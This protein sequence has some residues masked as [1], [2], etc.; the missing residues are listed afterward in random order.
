MPTNS[1]ATHLQTIGAGTRVEVTETGQGRPI[2]FLHPGIGL[3]GAEPFLKALGRLGRVV[4]PAHPGFHNSPAGDF[5]TIDDLSYLY[6]SLLESLEEPALVIGSSLGGWLALEAA[7]KSTANMAG[8]VLVNSVG[9]RFNTR[10]TPDFADLYALGSGELHKRMYHDPSVAKIDYPNT[11]MPEL[12]IIARNRE[13]E[14]RFAWAPYLHN[15]RLGSRLHRVNIP[16]L[17]VWGESDTFA[18]LGYGRKL[19]DALPS[20]LFETIEK[21]GHFPHIEQPNELVARIAR[22]GRHPAQ[23]VGAQRTMETAR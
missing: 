22:F 15:P 23:G 2:L 18:P 12:E 13:A 3:R 5:A 6:V 4:A 17:V 7:V 14:A 9:V 16:T 11:P 1:L 20:A 10:E 21:A 19:A 8:L